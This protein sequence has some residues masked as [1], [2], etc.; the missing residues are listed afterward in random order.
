MNVG[1]LVERSK[2][3]VRPYYL[4]WVYF[5]FFADRPES[6]T[7]C[8]N[9]PTVNVDEHRSSSEKQSPAFLFLP[10]TDWHFRR[11]RSQ[12]LAS[13][14]AARGH[15]CYFLNPHLGRQFRRTYLRDCRDRAGNLGERLTELH[16]RLPVEPVYHHRLL[17]QSETGRLASVIEPI[18]AQNRSVVQMLSFPTWGQL[19]FT[20]RERYGWPVI[21][22]C[23]DLLE[24][25]PSVAREIVEAEIALLERSDRVV[26]SS[27]H[28]RKT[29]TRRASIRPDR[30][31]LLRNAV[32]ARFVASIAP[33][34]HQTER[35]VAG[36]F[37]A[38]ES[39]FDAEAIRLAAVRNPGVLFRLIGR[40]QDQSVGSL[41]TIPNVELAGEM[42]HGE[43]PHEL[44]GFSAGLIPFR[45]NELTRAA[46]PIKLYEYFS[47][48][49]PVISTRLPEVEQYADLLYLA[50]SPEQFAS[51]VQRAI[52]ESDRSL[53]D[54]RIEIARAETWDRRADQLLALTAQ[55]SA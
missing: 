32:D 26:F 4:R 11:Q 33:A 43:L 53:R 3:I 7:A 34:R 55:L 24:G 5:P 52:D 20:L 47:A 8:W 50:D 36:Y 35:P 41:A 25:F 46:N 16:L 10:M 30:I 21:Y 29:Y 6:F 49:L 31:A 45:V 14:L 44:A 54:R 22:D 37:G 39:W 48:G 12:H 13:S 28:L 38:L 18:A 15:Q 51:Q 42:P 19:A 23:H 1:R 9:Y 17:T 40:V 2:E 27:E